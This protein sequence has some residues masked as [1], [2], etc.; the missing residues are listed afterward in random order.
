MCPVDCFHE[1]KTMLVIDPEYCVDCGVCEPECPVDAI[2]SDKKPEGERWVA[3]NSQYAA[4]WPNITDMTKKPFPD[5]DQ[6]ADV[7]D[8]MK[9]HFNPEPADN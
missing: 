7:P 2:V 6:W 5:A 9:D 4:L 1:G 3:F 8:K